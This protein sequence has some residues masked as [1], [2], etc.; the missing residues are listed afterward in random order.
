MSQQR[1]QVKSITG[2]SIN[3]N[4]ESPRRESTTYWVADTANCHKEVMLIREHRQWNRKNTYL[5]YTGFRTTLTKHVAEIT[6]RELNKRY[7]SA[8]L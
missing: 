6:A 5:V 1:F 7:D 4:G 8:E 3:P 2:F